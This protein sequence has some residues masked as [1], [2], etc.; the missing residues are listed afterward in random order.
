MPHFFSISFFII[1]RFHLFILIRSHSNG[2]HL[3]STT[4]PN[5]LIKS[6]RFISIF[7]FSH[8]YFSLPLTVSVFIS[9]S[10]HFKLTDD[11]AFL[12]PAIFFLLV[13]FFFSFNF[14]KFLLWLN[15]DFAPPKIVVS[16]GGSF[17][18]QFPTLNWHSCAIFRLN[19]ST[20]AQLC[21]SQSKWECG[22]T[23]N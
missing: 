20:I 5:Y 7:A 23:R 10:F 22:I 9:S 2:K 4:N 3:R 21:G 16:F 19:I 18:R 13:S 6:V 17:S 15:K 14:Y 12:S 11:M 1:W 8:T